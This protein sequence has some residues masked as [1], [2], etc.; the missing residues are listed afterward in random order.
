MNTKDLI[1]DIKAHQ[2]VIKCVKTMHTNS[3]G[4]TVG[5]RIFATAGDKNDKCIHVWDMTTLTNMTTLR[6]HKGEIRA[7]EFSRDGKY[8]FSAGQGGML[9]W[10]LRNTDS[11]IELIE[12]HMDIFSLKATNDRLFMGCRNHSIITVGLSSHALFQDQVQQ[13]LYP[14]HL[15]VV[16]SFTSLHDERVIIS[17]SKDKSLRGWTSTPRTDGEDVH[18]IQHLPNI[19]VSQ[20]HT[21]HINVLESSYDQ[22]EMYSG[23]KDG[24]V[25]V[26][27]LV[28]APADLAQQEEQPTGPNDDL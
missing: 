17:A 3:D 18:D 28:E 2:G 9:V 23:S 8:L 24:I 22:I 14:P 1:S 25:H 16:T 19:N 6:G 4:E 13:P 15:D 10:D 7:L 11:P 20:A 21:D 26:W 27:N 12:K 5:D